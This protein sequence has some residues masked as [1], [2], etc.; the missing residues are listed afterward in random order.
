MTNEGK[1]SVVSRNV[2]REV[3]CS[4]TTCDV[5]GRC[6]LKERC[7]FEGKANLIDDVVIDDIEGGEKPDSRARN[8]LLDVAP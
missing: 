6:P 7:S 1:V 4:E 5:V 3:Q 8:A 2:I